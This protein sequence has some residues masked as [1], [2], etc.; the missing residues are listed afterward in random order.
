MRGLSPWK[1]LLWI[2]LCVLLVGIIY[3]WP[4]RNALFVAPASGEQIAAELGPHYQLFKPEGDGPFPAVAVFHGCAGPEPQL[5]LP[6]ATW[7]TQQG[8]VALLVDSF[9]GRGLSADRVCS[10]HQFWGNQRASD[11]YAALSHL[12]AQAFV[13]AERLALLGY[14][15]G[16]W[17]VLD[18]LTYNGERPLGALKAT[19]GA[20]RGVKAVV[21]YYPYCEFPAHFVTGWDASVPVL[22][23]LAGQ[24]SVVNVD[25]CLTLFD[26]MQSQGTAL[27]Y[28]LYPQSEHVFDGDSGMNA[29]DPL[30]AEQALST[31]AEF[32]TI[33]FNP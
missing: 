18:A 4:Y 23:L 26:R 25:A 29:Y 33:Q 2:L 10:G 12:R 11:V 17:T 14:S 28:E 13:D 16:G 5:S 32:L 15:H 8:Y 27:A 21:A 20:L 9:S 7:L 1:W 22:S 6:R 19:P 3:L 31:M 24:D 30:V